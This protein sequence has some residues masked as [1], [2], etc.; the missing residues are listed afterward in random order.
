[1]RLEKRDHT[2][3]RISL[4]MQSTAFVRPVVGESSQQ[5]EAVI[6]DGLICNLNIFFLIFE[7]G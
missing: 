5:Q 2:I 7:I 1:M 6:F 3:F 4:H